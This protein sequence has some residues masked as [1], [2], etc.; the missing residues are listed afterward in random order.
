MRL[1]KSFKTVN[2]FLLIVFLLIPG[3]TRAAENLDADRIVAVVNDMIVT[4]S[5]IQE[6]MSFAYMQL[7]TRLKGKQ[8]EDEMDRIGK[9]ALTRLVEDKLILQEAVKQGIAANEAVINARIGE[10]KTRFGS[11]KK[12]DETLR[13]QNMSISELKKSIRDQELMKAVV[14]KEI[15]AKIYVS[16]NEITQFYRAHPEEFKE[17]EGRKVS[18]LVFKERDKARI[19]LSE[20]NNG[21]DFG[22]ISAGN[23]DYQNS[24]EIRRGKLTPVVENQIFSLGVGKTSGII[25]MEDQFYIFRILALLPAK[26]YS[27]PETQGL[28][29]ENIFNAK[30]ADSLTAWLDKLKEKAYIVIK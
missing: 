30:M 10:M 28:I 13:S 25:N 18:F 17:P 22:Q 4:Y 7:A 11:E 1:I 20:I 15:R 24:R 6:Y 2:I 19:A 29:Y 9:E 23:P 12:F 16:P 27:L 14:D 3:F 5:E 8:L 21:K 26:L